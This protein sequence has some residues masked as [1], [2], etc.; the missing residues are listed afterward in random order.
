MA[1]PDVRKDAMLT[2]IP[3]DQQVVFILI[4]TESGEALTACS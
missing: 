3:V 4:E 2:V 1:Q